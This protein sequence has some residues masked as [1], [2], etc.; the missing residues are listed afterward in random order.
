MNVLI[1]DD[2]SDIVSIIQELLENNNYRTMTALDGEDG[3]L[4]Y[5]DFKPEVVIT[6]IEMPKRNGFQLMKSI[7]RHDPDIKTIYMT[8]HVGQFISAFEEETVKYHAAFLEKPFP[9]G[10]LIG[11]LDNRQ[12]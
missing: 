7:R 11:L 12:C 6:D 4:A 1:V 5:L 8:A 9:L 2:S 10:E 3:Y